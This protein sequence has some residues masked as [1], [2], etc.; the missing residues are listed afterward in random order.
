MILLSVSCKSLSHLATNGS[1]GGSQSADAFS[2]QELF[3]LADHEMLVIY[4]RSCNRGTA[5][6][7]GQNIQFHLQT[8]ARVNYDTTSPALETKQERKKRLFKT[9]NLVIDKDT[10]PQKQVKQIKG[11]PGGFI[12]LD[13]QKL[14][15]FYDLKN[16]H[17]QKQQSG[18]Y[19]ENQGQYSISNV[20]AVIDLELMIDYPVRNKSLFK[21]PLSK[22]DMDEI[23][24]TPKRFLTKKIAGADTVT[25]HVTLAIF[26]KDNP[27][28]IGVIP[29]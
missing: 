3:G 13:A 15:D 27:N 10:D 16:K 12:V 7:L 4:F 25:A 1:E 17:E 26:N 18:G 2:K 24:A 29:K 22:K 28:L 11:D 20:Q 23:R 19:E 6:I 14:N 9:R 5:W 8:K 21:L